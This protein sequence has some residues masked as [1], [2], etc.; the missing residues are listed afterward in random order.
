MSILNIKS[1]QNLKPVVF[2]YQS[3]DSFT[4]KSE[5]KS[6]NN[7]MTVNMLN[8]FNSFKDVSLNNKNILVLTDR[9]SLSGVFN[10]Y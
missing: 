6:Y 1:L 3:Q 10:N 4:F 2:T 7:G 8:A 9:Q 5:V